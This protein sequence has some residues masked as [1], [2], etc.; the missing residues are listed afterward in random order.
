MGH[1]GRVSMQG[2]LLTEGLPWHYWAV[3]RSAASL[4][5]SLAKLPWAF[6]PPLSLQ[7]ENV[8]QGTFTRIYRGFKQDPQKEVGDGGPRE[9][10]ATE[11]ILKVLDSSHSHLAEVRYGKGSLRAF[12]SW[13]TLPVGQSQE[14]WLM[15]GFPKLSRGT[16][17]GHRPHCS[18]LAP[19][20]GEANF[21]S[22]GAPNQRLLPHA[23]QSPGWDIC[24]PYQG[25]EKQAVGM[26][27]ALPQSDALS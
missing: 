18:T 2:G 19:S 3:G 17:R 4:A 23:P 1:P 15:R 5:E 22:A 13:T 14:P 16:R 24:Q 20:P 25:G 9:V 21:V 7:G 12:R 8:G 10:P 6:R 27:G 11:V 26:G